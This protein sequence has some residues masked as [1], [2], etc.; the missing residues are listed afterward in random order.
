M[1]TTPNNPDELASER[2]LRIR[3]EGL[4]QAFVF[5]RSTGR[6]R[7]AIDRL[8]FEYSGGAQTRA[9]TDNSMQIYESCATLQ[10]TMVS[11]DPKTYSFIDLED[12]EPDIF[13]LYGE[14]LGWKARFRQPARERAPQTGAA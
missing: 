7:Q 9:I 4:D 14:V 12:A 3:S 8:I 1:A 10:A 6:D 2:E 5:R 11:P 13:M